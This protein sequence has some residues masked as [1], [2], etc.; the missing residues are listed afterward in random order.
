[1]LAQGFYQLVQFPF[2]AD[3]RVDRV[4]VDDVVA[5]RA[6]RPR[7][8]ERRCVEMADP[9]PREIRHQ[10]DRIGEAELGVELEAIGRIG[11]ALR[12]AARDGSLRHRLCMRSHARVARPGFERERQLAAP[13]GMLVDAAR[14]VR[15]LEQL[16]HILGLE[17][18][19]LARRA[20]DVGVRR[21]RR[22]IQ[23]CTLQ[24]CQVCATQ[25]ALLLRV[26]AEAQALAQVEVVLRPVAAPGRQVVRAD[27]HQRVAWIGLRRR[28][29]AIGLFLKKQWAVREQP[30]GIQLG[31]QIGRHRAE[32]LADHQ[33]FAPAA[34]GGQHGEQIVRRVVHVTALVCLGAARDPVQAR[35]RHDVVHAQRAAGGHVGAQQLDERA[36][37]GS[38]QRAR[39]VRRQAPV[40]SF[41][42]E[43]VGRRAA[44]GVERVGLLVRPHLRAAAVGAEREID[45]EPDRHAE[46]VRAVLHAFELRAGDALHPL[47]EGDALRPLFRECLDGAARRI[48]ILLRPALPAAAEFLAQRFEDGEGARRGHPGF[49]LLEDQLEDIALEDRHA[50]VVDERRFPQLVELALERL[51]LHQALR[52]AVLRQR[53]DIQIQEVEREPAGRAIGAALRGVQRIHADHGG[54]AR[55][56]ELDQRAQVAEVADAPVALRAHAVELHHEAPDA[57]ALREELG[58]VAAPGLELDLRR[59]ARRTQCPRERRARRGVDL[60]LAPP[61]VEV[62]LSDFSHLEFGDGA[63]IRSG[64]VPE[65]M[66][67]NV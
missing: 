13:V 65:L 42:I 64:S 58:L 2:G 40:L 32:V 66:R 27:A 49:R 16:E 47:V 1:V 63:R 26:D 39:R 61:D 33:A 36:V 25:L 37:A 12:P 11:Y 62:A 19:D 20:R 52:C 60:L 38:L 31:A 54:A 15:L 53:L 23:A 28:H 5:V 14:K 43:L 17:E 55:R 24:S 3:L 35:E 46:L 8:E 50:G 4:V 67:I 7:L 45:V 6:A 10:L 51:G 30:R 56:G 29:L 34:L 57:A 18:R 21:E 22:A 41:R 9:Q 59:L 44:G 48:A